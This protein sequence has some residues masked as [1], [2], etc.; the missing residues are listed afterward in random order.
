MRRRNRRR[1]GVDERLPVELR[2]PPPFTARTM[3]DDL[4]AWR[5][6]AQA[7][8]QWREAHDPDRAGLGYRDD[9]SLPWRLA[10]DR[11]GA[12]WPPLLGG[13]AAADA[14]ALRWAQHQ[15]DAGPRRG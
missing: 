7:R 1:P 8:H 4:P 11:W 14:Q 5:R 15:A 13:P 12:C 3:D 6:W 2:D 9:L 10:L